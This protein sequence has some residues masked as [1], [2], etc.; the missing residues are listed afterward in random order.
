MI[1]PILEDIGET[2]PDT[3]A[4]PEGDAEYPRGH[5]LSPTVVQAELAGLQVPNGSA[6]AP[7]EGH[8]PSFLEEVLDEI[9]HGTLLP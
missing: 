8:K 2:E 9:S 3:I 5:V 4:T 7:P 1:D 6:P